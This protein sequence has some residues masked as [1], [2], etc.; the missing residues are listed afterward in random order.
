MPTIKLVDPEIFSS[1]R[2]RTQTEKY[3][4]SMAGTKYSYAVTQLETQGVIN[5]DVHM[6]VQEEF[7]Q[8]EPDVVSSIMTQL[9]IRSGMREWGDKAYTSVQSEMKQLYFRN[10]F[11]LKHWS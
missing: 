10:T 1:S 6:F 9:S 7:Y 3:T 4:L 2:V 11:N 5:P 8:T